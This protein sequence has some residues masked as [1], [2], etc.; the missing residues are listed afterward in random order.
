[1][2]KVTIRNAEIQKAKYCKGL[3]VKYKSYQEDEFTQTPSKADTLSPEFNHSKV[4]SFT[5]I[6][7]E[8]LDWFENGCITF[9]LYGKQEDSIPDSRLMK[10]TTKV[11]QLLFAIYFH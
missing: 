4:F 8:H 6:T 1:M 5:A 7:Q 10:M 3:Y 9:M 11:S 2:Y